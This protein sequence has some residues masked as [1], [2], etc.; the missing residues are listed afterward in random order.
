MRKTTKLTPEME[1]VMA[2]ARRDGAVAAGRGAHAGHVEHVAASTVLALI[3]RGLL[4]H[5]YSSEG[6]LGGKLPKVE[7]ICREC[8]GTYTPS[9][10]D[11]GFCC[12]S[13]MNEYN[14][15]LGGES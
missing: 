14:E 5:C 3:S 9:D 10:K 11:D 6:G 2:I 15:S 13:C 4:V 7:K 1:R 8:H 12:D